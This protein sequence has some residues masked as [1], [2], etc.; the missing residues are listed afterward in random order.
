MKVIKKRKIEIED[1]GLANELSGEW[2]QRVVT[3]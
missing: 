1:D 2:K 3:L